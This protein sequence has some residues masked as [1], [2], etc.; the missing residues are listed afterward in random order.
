MN[1][2]W[3]FIVTEYS[4]YNPAKYD[5]ILERIEEEHYWRVGTRTRNRT[6]VESH[7][8]VVFYLT[9]SGNQCFIAQ[10]KTASALQDIGNRLWG[11]L[12]LSDFVR[13]AEPLPIRSIISKLEFIKRK[14]YWWRYLQGGITS[15][16]IN[17]FKLIT[18]EAIVA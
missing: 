9:G 6:R 5:M 17:D 12:D 10:A 7:D 4:D 3:I 13:F 11:I 18:S 15:I 16:T 2:N 14:E 8:N 1:Q